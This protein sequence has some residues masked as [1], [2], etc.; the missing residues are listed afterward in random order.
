MKAI[1][2]ALPQAAELYR[3]KV[4]NLGEALRQADVERARQELRDAVGEIRI[5]TENGGAV[6]EICL[7]PASAVAL[8]GTS[9][10]GVVAGARF[11]NFRRR[12]SLK[13]KT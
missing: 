2:A 13:S 6:A 12:L 5:V 7:N 8:T 9:K 1:M 11:A 3:A 4:A 10:I